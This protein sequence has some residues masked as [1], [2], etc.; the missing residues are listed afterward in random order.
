M[1]TLPQVNMAYSQISFI[2]FF[3]APLAVAVMKLLPPMELA[4]DTMLETLD[5]W[6]CGC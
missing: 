3:V 1:I 6:V 2:E 4:A 5:N